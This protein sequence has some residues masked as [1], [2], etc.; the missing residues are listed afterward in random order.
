MDRL[1]RGGR[2]LHPVTP[3]GKHRRAGYRPI[4]EHRWPARI[5]WAPLADRCTTLLRKCLWV[6][7]FGVL[8][9]G[10]GTDSRRLPG[11]TAGRP[12]DQPGKHRRTARTP[13]ATPAARVI[14]LSQKCRWTSPFGIQRGGRGTAG[15][16]LDGSSTP[17]GST[18]MRRGGRGTDPSTLVGST[19]GRLVDHRAPRAGAS[20]GH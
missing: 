12:I 16:T 13:Q 9:G 17:L 19:G 1:L 10:R 18:G 6:G 20:F 7:S 2:G 8:R 15:L 14:A 3:T 11:S 4:R 5:S